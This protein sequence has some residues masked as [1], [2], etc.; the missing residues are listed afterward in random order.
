M[1]GSA[2]AGN[3]E[4]MAKGTASEIKTDK[5]LTAAVRKLALDLGANLVGVAP[6]VRWKNAPLRNSPQGLLPGSRT[7]VVCALHLLD[8]NIELGANN[9][10]REPGTGISTLTASVH[11]GHIA[12]KIARFLEGKG[13]QSLMVPTT[14]WWNYRKDEGAPRGWMPDIAH[15]YAAAAAGLGDLGWNNLCLTPEFGPRQ[16][17]ISVI[18]KAPLE[19]DPMYRGTPLCDKCMLC[20]KNCP[21]QAY[22][23]EV[24]GM[25]VIDYGEKKYTFPKKNLWRCSVG[26]NFILDVK[27]KWPEKIDEQTIVE[28]GKHSVT[29]RKDLNKNWK[30]GICLKYCMT[31]ERRYFDKAFTKSPRRRRDVEPEY[32]PANIDRAVR[33]IKDFAEKSAIDIV[34]IAGDEKYCE[35]GIKLKDYLPT[36]RSGVLIGIDSP[37]GWGASRGDLKCAALCLANYI[38]ETFGFDVLIETALD[39]PSMSY[40]RNTVKMTPLGLKIASDI[41]GL[42]YTDK[43]GRQAWHTIICS[44]PFRGKDVWTRD[45][46]KLTLP[47]SRKSPHYLTAALKKLA[48]SEGADLFGVAPAERID[49]AA[50]QL[51]KI[52]GGL[53]YFTLADKGWGI[54]MSAA[55]G[56]PH[57]PAITEEKLTPKHPSDYIKNAGSVIV[58]GMKMLEGSVENAGKAPAYKAG[59]YAGTA[60]GEYMSALSK[61]ARKLAVIL[62]ANGYKSKG[63]VDFE[64]LGSQVF[65]TKQPGLRSSRFA[66]LA[67]GLGEIGWNGQLLTRE[68]GPRQR[69]YTII[70]D[71][72]LE[73]D[74]VYN[75]EP[76]CCKCKKCVKSCPVCA[77]APDSM[78]SIELDG[79]VFEWGSEDVLRCDWAARYAL[80]ADEGPKYMGSTNDFKPPAKITREALL[81]AVNASDL[82]ALTGYCPIIERCATECPAGRKNLLIDK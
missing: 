80:V 31:P 36:G 53:D 48:L 42:D 75:G 73:Y 26:E 64:G 2:F 81:Q 44:F 43:E 65:S 71:A 61:I 63:A 39:T 74:Q 82:F 28:Y 7:V 55:R 12:L 11:L 16:R 5:K 20:A 58:I 18:T 14:G 60:H 30:M 8:C 4:S 72:V 67:A 59:H 62:D 41:Y 3:D 21:M 70:T 49:K 33:G 68:F 19:P 6:A 34:G 76:I 15:F 54:N 38:Q 69:F 13:W 40:L 46:S 17:F 66:A 50:G 9:D 56:R 57:N 52:Y 1:A 23:K 29:D 27:A 78:N 22:D 51:E 37:S 25:I 10:V 24:D 45:K 35:K 32:S 79:K 47:A 77:I